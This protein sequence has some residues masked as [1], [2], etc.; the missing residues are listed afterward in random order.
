[1]PT[2]K[3]EKA[4]TWFCKF[5]YTDWNGKKVQKKKSGFKLKRDAQEWE[6]NFLSAHEKSCTGMDVN[7][8]S[9]LYFENC[10]LKLKPTSCA[11]KQNIIKKH[12]LPTFGH[13]KIVDITPNDIRLWHNDLLKNNNY[14]ATYL[15]KIN[16]QL[17]GLFNFAVKYY[18]LKQNPVAMCDSIGK[19]K[20][21]V[22]QFWTPEEFKTFVEYFVNDIELYAIFHMLFYTGVRIGELLALAWA[23]IN[24]NTNMLHVNKNMGK[25]KGGKIILTPKTEKSF[26]DIILPS[27]LCDILLNYK[28]QIYDTSPDSQVF[29]KGSYTIRNALKR[30]CN[31]TG[32]KEIR[33]HDFRHSH[34]SLLIECGFSPLAIADRLGHENIQTTLNTYGHLYPNKQEEIA[35][36]LNKINSSST[37]SVLQMQKIAL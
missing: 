15:R 33:L 14:K 19:S 23:D 7:K 10:K 30:G 29:N 4:N 6:N 17:S 32:I 16:A 24:F 9:E 8:V 2:Y 22:M 3:N 25:I 28:K 31:K 36:K 11:D 35:D 5:Y 1:M 27:F 21:N 34:A 20:A 18:N 12:I 13:L 26:R 37:F